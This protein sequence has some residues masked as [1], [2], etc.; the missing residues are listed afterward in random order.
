MRNPQILPRDRDLLDRLDATMARKRITTAELLAAI[1]EV[2]A[3]RLH[4]DKGYETIFDYCVNELRMDDDELAGKVIAARV[5]RRYPAIFEAI[6]DGR[7]QLDGVV[8][9]APYLRD[10]NSG[11]LLATAANRTHAEVTRLI[12]DRFPSGFPDDFDPAL[13]DPLA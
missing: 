2:E 10:T 6:A 9:L 7:L 12:M 3:R 11:E 5:A 8:L 13:T 4:A 1:G